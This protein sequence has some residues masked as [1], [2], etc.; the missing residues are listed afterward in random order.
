M[1][2]NILNDFFSF[3][4]YSDFGYEHI[5]VLSFI[6]GILFFIPLPYYPIPII[7]TF[8][9]NLDPLLIS[10]S[11][12]LGT[13]FAKMILFYLSYCGYNILSKDTKKRLISLQKLVKTYGWISAFIGAVS[14][15]SGNII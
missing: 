11:G 13:L 10:I 8:D 7:A 2:G 1:D 14:P 12:S 15:I 9:K 6:I 3:V 4:Y 5:V